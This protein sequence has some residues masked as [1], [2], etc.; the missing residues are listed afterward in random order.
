[1]SGQAA[2]NLATIRPGT[3]EEKL[4]AAATAGFS[5]VGLLRQEMEAA[6]DEGLEELHLSQLAVSELT[7]LSGWMDADRN[8]R[9]IALV[10]AERTF[11]MAARLGCPLVNA[12][13]SPQAVDLLAAAA[14]FQELCRTAELLEIRVGLEFLGTREHLND[15]AGAWEVIEAAGVANGGLVID[16]FHFYRGGSALEMLDPIPGEKIFLVQVSDCVDLPRRELEDRHRVYP[17]TGAIPLEP[18]LGAVRGKGY[19]G[20]YSLE[21]HNEAYWQEDPLTV[22]RE[23]L[24]AMRN[25]DIN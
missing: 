18:L 6:G 15:L 4:Y 16:T 7:G 24:R 19:S 5:A 14:R 22:A 10:E 21:L 17:G 3:L 8:T 20:Y 9:A 11:E 1:M 2:L 13:P 23:G 25:L 12:W